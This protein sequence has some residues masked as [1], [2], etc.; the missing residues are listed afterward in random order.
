MSASSS[1]S[2]LYTYEGSTSRYKYSNSKMLPLASCQATTAPA[3]TTSSSVTRNNSATSS[4]R[5]SA[6]EKTGR[7]N[8]SSHLSSSR[9]ASRAKKSKC[10]LQCNR[11]LLLPKFTRPFAFKITS[12][13]LRH[14]VGYRLEIPYCELIR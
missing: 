8:I 11:I 2:K 3:S 9:S 7:N 13:L 1:D 12:Q 5:F 14:P 6:T 4:P 10:F